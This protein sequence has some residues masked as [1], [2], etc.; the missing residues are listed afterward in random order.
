VQHGY[1]PD[2][3]RPG[4]A[5]GPDDTRRIGDDPDAT[6]RIG[7]AAGA[8][9]HGRILGGRYR[10]EG[11]LGTGG[12]SEVHRGTDLRLDR[13]V[14]V[15]LFRAGTDRDSLRRFTEEAHTLA[16]LNHPGLVAV[17]DSGAERDQPYLVMELVN[18]W[19][20]REVAQQ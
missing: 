17:Y 20:L 10:L 9:G 8:G 4:G 2:D 1:G 13:P 6:R 16:N 18:G 11:S 5:P 14:A 3:P 12:M 7:P 15:K 19:S